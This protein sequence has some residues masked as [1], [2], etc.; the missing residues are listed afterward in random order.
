MATI[1]RGVLGVSPKILRDSPQARQLVSGA[2]ALFAAVVVAAPPFHQTEWPVPKL[3][4]SPPPAVVLAG[5]LPLT[6]AQT[7]PFSAKDWPLPRGVFESSIARKWERANDLPRQLQQTLPFRVSEWPSAK[8]PLP[9][10]PETPALNTAT[11]TVVVVASPFASLDW[12]LPKRPLLDVPDW[13]ALSV[14]SQ[15]GP[16]PFAFYEWPLPRKIALRTADTPPI[17]AVSQIGPTPFAF[18]DWA[19]AKKASPRAPEPIWPDTVPQVGP[20]PFASYDW[21]IAKTT[22]RAAPP[23]TPYLNVAATRTVVAVAAPF[24]SFDWPLSR[25]PLLVAKDTPLPTSIGIRTVVVVTKPFALL[26]W[27]LAKKRIG[28]AEEPPPNTTVATPPPP[29]STGTVTAT[30]DDVTLAGVSGTVPISGERVSHHNSGTGGF[31]LGRHALGTC[32]MCAGVYLLRELRPEIY[33]LRPTGFLVCDECWD[34]DNP[35]LQVGRVPIFDPEALRNPR[36]DTHL[37]ESRELWGFNPV[38]NQSTNVLCQDG[39]VS[40]NDLFQFPNREVTP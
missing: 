13:Q 21:Q 14:V 32:D 7:L 18:Y 9:A 15:I 2:L 20:K 38:G 8:R 25:K 28:T 19:L 35:Q 40:V 17:S 5:S 30:L 36:A 37:T 33:N 23:D 34:L 29:P 22:Q 39:T 3:P 16:T 27:P 12:P 26:D 6:T 10:A 11:R 24:A 1:F 31:A 4:K